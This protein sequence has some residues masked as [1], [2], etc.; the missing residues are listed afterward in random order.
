MGG[1]EAGASTTPTSDV[2]TFGAAIAFVIDRL[3]GGGALVADTGGSTRWGISKNAHPDIDVE[4]LDRATAEGIYLDRYWNAVRA[5]ELPRGLALLVFDAAVNLGPP[6]A[7]KLLQRVLG[8][9]DDG[10]VGPKTL[11]AA[12]RFRPRSELRA[13][14]NEIRLRSYEELAR[15]KPKFRPYLHGWR[16]RVMRVA[17]EAGRWGGGA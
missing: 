14:F 10:I 8:L 4:H 6:Q 13:L 3:E 5:S 2:E 12:D 9:R 17:D 1:P 16:M 7:A 11:A 15:T